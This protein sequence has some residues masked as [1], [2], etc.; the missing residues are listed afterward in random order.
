VNRARFRS[1]F[2]TAAFV[3]LVATAWW[4]IAPTQIGGSTSYVV[5]KGVS[6]EPDLRSGDLAVVR[7]E[8]RYKVGQI[9]A[10]HSSLLHVT[11][12]HR[13][14]RLDGNRYV[15]KGDNNNF[16]DPTRPTRGQVLGAL[17][18]RVPHGGAALTLLHAPIAA[19]MLCGALGL[20]LVLGV[21]DI[22]PHRRRR[23]RKGRQGARAMKTATDQSVSRAI[24]WSAILI[25][26]TVVA[27]VF[28]LVGVV[29]LTRPA[30][31]ATS[32][33]TAYT[34]QLSYGYRARA[35]AGAV[36][37]GGV[38]ATGDPIF[39][40]LVNHLTVHIDYRLRTAVQ[41]SMSGTEDVVL[42]ITGPGGWSRSI[43]L[44]PRTHFSGD[45]ASTD[46]TLDLP[47]V[48]SLL[49]RVARL[50][51]VVGYTGY[52]IAVV[53]E[54]HLTGSVAGQQ[55]DTT[56][57]RGLNF[58][59]TATQ[60]LPGA[61]SAV[62]P[63]TADVP[64]TGQSNS[65]L[66]QSQSGTVSSPASAPNTITVFGVSPQIVTLRWIAV[67]GLL[68][69]AGVALY[70]YLRKRSEPFGE[71]YRIQS[72]YGH[73]IVPVVTGEDLGWPP[74][75]V[76]DIK[77]L[78]KLAESGQRLILHNRANNVDT[79]ML[80]EEGTVYRYQVKPSNVVWGEWSETATEVDAT[81]TA[82]EATAAA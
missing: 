4:F 47:Q 74:V 80:N 8:S 53:P 14:V 33:Q 71:T 1:R 6:M 17:W 76:P 63:Q 81:E 68:L 22:G 5:T 38:V 59:L 72:Q 48:Q 25:G 62:S 31:R 29:T 11:V 21:R 7:P 15:F 73:M 64:G 10:Y 24:D 19:A 77:S 20:F 26:S 35:R 2:L 27:A 65:R 32:A 69:S 75:D 56:F 16:T 23:R 28:L 13:I 42:Q 34:Q 78:V 39:T 54:V 55:L 58:Q 36:Y 70:A 30:H 57:T 50:T 67:I 18:L 44:A 41:H 49:G 40:Q 45:H 52:T 82:A 60:L 66:T 12:L 79:Y 46:V 43:L 9:V 37:P 3:I 61:T 51:G